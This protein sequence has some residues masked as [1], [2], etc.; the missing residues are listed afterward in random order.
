LVQTPVAGLQLPAWWHWSSG[1]QT[2]GLAPVQEPDWQVSV[3]VHKSPSLQD[4]P[5][6]LAGSE[7]APV[8]GLHTP[9]SWHW[10]EGVQITGSKPVQVPDW[11]VS[12]WVQKSPSSQVDPS[13]FAGLVQT[14]VAGLQ[15]PALW[16]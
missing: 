13:G 4:V 6:G 1:V 16:H 15:L 11:Q 2:T 8:A 10:S 12:V 5:S 9:A 3:R 7:Q 14:P